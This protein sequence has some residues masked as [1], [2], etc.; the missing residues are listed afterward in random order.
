MM[1]RTVEQLLK[2]CPQCDGE[3]GYP[4]GLDEAACHTD[5]PRCLGIG[6]IVD[7]DA[8]LNRSTEEDRNYA[9]DMILREAGGRHWHEDRNAL[10]AVDKAY[11]AGRNAFLNTTAEEF[12]EQDHCSCAAEAKGAPADET[13]DVHGLPDDDDDFF[14]PGDKLI[15]VDDTIPPKVVGEWREKLS[16][17]MVKGQRYTVESASDWRKSGLGWALTLVE[18]PVPGLSSWNSNRF[19]HDSGDV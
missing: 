19:I 15:C 10:N 8:I 5:C 18:A 7:T 17:M 14:K 12:L 9:I 11:E 2:T 3:G 16:A 6:W 4:D 13:C 1:T